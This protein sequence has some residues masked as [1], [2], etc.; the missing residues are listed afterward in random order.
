MYGV[1]FLATTRN[2]TQ[3]G[4]EKAFSITVGMTKNRIATVELFDSSEVVGDLVDLLIELTVVG[5]AKFGIG[6]F[7]EVDE[8]F[9]KFLITLD[10]LF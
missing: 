3:D 4:N 5:P 2:H 10:E 9:G 7:A 8:V 1:S 6:D